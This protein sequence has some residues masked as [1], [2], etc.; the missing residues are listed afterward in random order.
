MQAG[1]KTLLVEAQCFCAVVAVGRYSRREYLST[2]RWR[3]DP[4]YQEIN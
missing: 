1:N 4:R 3:Q 2:M